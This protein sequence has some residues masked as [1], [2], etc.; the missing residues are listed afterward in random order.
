ME[1]ANY[2]KIDNLMLANEF[3]NK[4]LKESQI[5]QLPPKILQTIALILDN[6]DIGQATGLCRSLSR[7]SSEYDFK[8][9]A[10]QLQNNPNG[11]PLEI[12]NKTLKNINR[13]RASALHS[14]E[15][16]HTWYRGSFR[17]Q[18]IDKVQKELFDETTGAVREDKSLLDENEI[19]DGQLLNEIDSFNSI[20]KLGLIQDFRHF[21]E[22]FRR[23]LAD[24]DLNFNYTSSDGYIQEIKNYVSSPD[25]AENLI[26]AFMQNKNP[27]FELPVSNIIA[28]NFL[29]EGGLASELSLLVNHPNFFFVAI[30]NEY[31]E[32]IVNLL[33]NPN[34][35]ADALN[36][37]LQCGKIQSA[38]YSDPKF[39]EELLSR[40]KVGEAIANRLMGG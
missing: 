23:I 24:P 40:G 22:L 37:F 15:D 14:I 4:E 3:V 1:P 5:K 19:F 16:G 29:R 34:V 12:C 39:M 33:C 9:I 20:E 32:S 10:E 7:V 38:L 26:K 21:P 8:L 17:E 2:Q 30:P 11:I 25:V 31:I 18:L 6:G 35:D 36:V 13:I 28:E 27:E